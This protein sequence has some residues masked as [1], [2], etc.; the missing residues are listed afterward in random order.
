[1]NKLEYE[2]LM[3]CRIILAKELGVPPDDIDLIP[4]FECVKRSIEENCYTN[5][6]NGP[7]IFP[8]TE[9]EKKQLLGK[10]GPIIISKIF[11]EEPPFY[12]WA[13]LY[14]GIYIQKILKDMNGY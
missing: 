4:I 10:Y 3:N 7:I 11:N 5:R 1:M 12:D 8:K 6:E 9:E 2:F 14:K 13:E